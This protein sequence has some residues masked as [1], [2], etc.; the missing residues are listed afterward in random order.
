MNH[1]QLRGQI[2]GQL[3]GESP[4]PIDVAIDDRSGAGPD[5]PA[6]ESVH[7]DGAAAG[8]ATAT[9]DDPAPLTSIQPVSAD[10]PGVAADAAGGI[11]EPVAPMI[12]RA[13]EAAL[14]TAQQPLT[15]SD[16]RRLFDEDVGTAVV[17][18]ALDELRNDWA[19]RSVGLVQL[20][21]GWRFQSAPDLGEYLARLS[22]EKPPRYSRAVMET[23]AIIAY[24]Q[25][26]TRGDI[27][28][29][30]GV[31]VSSPV[32]KALEDRGWIET[33]GHKDV[34]GRPA[35]LATTR[36]FLDDLGLKSLTELPTL[37]DLI[38]DAGGTLTG[39]LDAGVPA[40]M[41]PEVS[42]P[43]V[44]G[45]LGGNGNTPADDDVAAA[46]NDTGVDGSAITTD[47]IDITGIGADD[48]PSPE[49]VLPTARPLESS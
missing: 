46:G 2:E 29:I 8:G 11:N 31:T 21:S 15:P 13:I 27:E 45:A 38:G 1:G 40:S 41:P 23:L 43:D 20:A 42:R 44:D 39:V 14:L 49:S 37:S 5:L 30:R 12:K 47:G 7:A 35:L 48:E 22:P 3:E 25:P 34:I 32:I 28:E 17:R 33:I 36:Q 19:G 18:R 4:D 16:L 10:D 26:V 9:I 24:R 6:D